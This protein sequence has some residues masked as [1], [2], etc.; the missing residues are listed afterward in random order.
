MRNALGL[1]SR[2]MARLD[3]KPAAEETETEITLLR[4]VAPE[5][6]E[7]VTAVIRGPVVVT[8]VLEKSVSL[9]VGRDTARR[10]LRRQH[11][12]ALRV[13]GMHVDA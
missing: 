12:S 13:L 4:K 3:R 1:A 8:K 7:V 6:F 5:R 9:M 11:E 2:P 10:S